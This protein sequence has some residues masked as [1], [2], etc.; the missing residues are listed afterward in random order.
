MSK[1]FYIHDNYK[2]PFRVEINDDD[3]KVTSSD[4]KIKLTFKA[5][6]IFIGESKKNKMT[7]FSKGYGSKFSGNSILLN[8][9]IN[10]YEFIG[11]VIYSFVTYDDIVSFSSPI[12]NNDV[13]YPYA[14][15]KIGNIYLFIERVIL[16]HTSKLSKLIKKYDDNPYWYYYQAQL[17]TPNIGVIPPQKPLYK[18]FNNIKEYY[19]ND[20][21]YT[22][23]YVSNS[24]E[25]YNRLI[26]NFGK[27][28]YIIDLKNNKIKLI[29][30]KYVKIIEDF[31]KLMHLEPINIIKIDA[32]RQFIIL[33]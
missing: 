14:I 27:N 16:K 26:S 24:K 5:K 28:M 6:K 29:K 31:G 9:D 17:I 11:E 33:N 1:K 2:K 12:G 22:L 32:N 18:N 19:I 21:K 13:P 23:R 3:V 10:I 7:E 8:L 4:K 25:D 15:D 30:T 20:D